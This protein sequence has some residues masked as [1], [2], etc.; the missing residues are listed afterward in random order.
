LSVGYFC[1]FLAQG[2]Q[3]QQNLRKRP[4]IVAMIGGAL[5]LLD[6]CLLVAVD[7]S[8]AEKNFL[9]PGKLPMM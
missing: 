9:S 6:P 7:S 5:E 2:R 4:Q 8:E 3:R 1:L